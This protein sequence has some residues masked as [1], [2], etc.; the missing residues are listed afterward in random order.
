MPRKQTPVFDVYS[1][2]AS[3]EMN[4]IFVAYAL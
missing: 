3:N 4:Y 2:C 1:I